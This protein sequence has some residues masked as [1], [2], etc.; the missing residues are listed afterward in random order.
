MVA[1]EQIDG[2]V[3]AIDSFGN[4]LTNIHQ[5]HIENATHK[6][7]VQIG[8][9]ELS[10]AE[11]YSDHSPGEVLSL[12]GS[13]GWLEIAVNLGNAAELLDAGRGEP[14]RVAW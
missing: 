6:P 7:R 4:L 14:V 5:R 1:K 12:I 11:T 8:G 13:S 10:I 2:E 3:V 9:R